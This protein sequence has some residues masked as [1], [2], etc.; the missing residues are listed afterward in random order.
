MKIKWIWRNLVVSVALSR[1]SLAAGDVVTDWNAAALNTIRT[2]STAPPPASRALA[3]L[4]I[5]IYDAVNG[6]LRTHEP[7]FV[8]EK[9]PTNSSEEAEAS[10]AA[11]KVLITLFPT[12]AATFDQ[13]HEATLTRIREDS[14]KRRGL[15]W[16]ESVAAQILLW[17]D[18]DGF[19]KTVTPPTGSGP[20]VWRPPPPGYLAY[21]FPQWGFVT[22][23]AIPTSSFFRPNGPPPLQSARYA[24]D[25]NEMKALGAATSAQRTSEQTEIALFWAD[26]AGTVTPPGHWNVIASDVATVPFSTTSDG[27][28]NT[29]R[30]F[31]GF[32][33][34]ARR[35]GAQPNVRRHSFQLGQRRW[36]SGGVGDRG[37]DVQENDA[38]EV[39]PRIRQ[40]AKSRA[41]RRIPVA[42][43]SSPSNASFRGG[44]SQARALAGPAQLWPHAGE[45]HVQLNCDLR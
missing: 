9:G 24:A 14:R 39:T 15:E 31:R 12:S 16:G 5:S 29:V 2:S 20:G 22:P 45:R 11:H 13:L 3:I 17:R 30:D 27:L 19:D 44:P 41:N 6:I 21:A 18:D 26:G 36:L 23:F 4:H 38:P 7:Y 42:T 37:V 40:L 10:A 1:A 34:A 25:Y 33:Q 32:L 35:G 28:P 43:V 8:R